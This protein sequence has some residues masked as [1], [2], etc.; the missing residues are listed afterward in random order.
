MLWDPATS[1]QSGRRTEREVDTSD[2]IS[3]QID[4]DNFFDSNE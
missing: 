4:D 1:M 2:N 3:N